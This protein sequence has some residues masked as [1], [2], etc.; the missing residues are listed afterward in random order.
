MMTCEE[1]T[2][3]K[4]PPQIHKAIIA[5]MRAIGP[6]GKDS[7]NEQ[8]RYNFRGIDAVYNACHPLF[9]EHG[10]YSTSEILSSKHDIVKSANGKDY[11]HAILQIRFTY[12]TEDGSSVSTEVVGEGQDY[13]G[14]KASNKAMSTADK[15][16]LLQLLKIPVA[17]VDSDR[18][19]PAENP[20]S[21]PDPRVVP[22]ESRD[23][24]QPILDRFNG[25][26]ERWKI[27]VKRDNGFAEPQDWQKFV[28][29]SSAGIDPANCL[30]PAAWTARDCDD[31]DAAVVVLEKKVLKDRVS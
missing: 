24:R 15:Y 8:Q 26:K 7:R 14:D 28:C 22:R 9:A 2:S 21:R 6:I 4:A 13:G 25:I 31:V 11:N 3:V 27:A 10:V 19:T 12:W 18:G 17:M 5:I 1:E 20:A 16:A 23:N 30:R 29:D